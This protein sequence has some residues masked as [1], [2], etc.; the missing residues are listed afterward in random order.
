MLRVISVR[1]V[2]FPGSIDLHTV[3]HRHLSAFSVCLAQDLLVSCPLHIP[4]F[5]RDFGWSVFLPSVPATIL[6]NLLVWSMKLLSWRKT[7]Q[8]PNSLVDNS[9]TSI[10]RHLSHFILLLAAAIL[11]SPMQLSCHLKPRGLGGR[12]GK[13]LLCVWFPKAFALS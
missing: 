7:V 12:W 4:F 6:V 11:H 8:M 3:N 5:Q 2:Q 13:K 9:Q 1:Y 10:Q